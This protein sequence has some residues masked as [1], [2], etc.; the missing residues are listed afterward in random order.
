M[1]NGTEN[2]YCKNLQQ[3][4]TDDD[5]SFLLLISSHFRTKKWL[6]KEKE[7]TLKR[8]LSVIINTWSDFIWFLTSVLCLLVYLNFL[9][10]CVIY[11]QFWYYFVCVF[12]IISFYVTSFYCILFCFDCYLIFIT[13]LYRFMH[14][15]CESEGNN[16]K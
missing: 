7:A 13:C 12:R 9:I 14:N 15:L 10:L 3:F 4:L 16:W 2:V 1:D 11:F 5:K 8:K 6:F